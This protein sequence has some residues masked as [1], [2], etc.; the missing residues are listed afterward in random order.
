MEVGFLYFVSDYRADAALL[1]HIIFVP[2]FFN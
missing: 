1:A 2:N